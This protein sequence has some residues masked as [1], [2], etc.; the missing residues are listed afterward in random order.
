DLLKEMH[1]LPKGPREYTAISC[2]HLNDGESA[3]MWKLYA[4]DNQGIA[5]QSTVAKLENSL[6]LPPVH[7]I[8]M[9]KVKYDPVEV[10]IYD[11]RFSQHFIFFYKRK[12]FEHEQEYRITIAPQD[13][14]SLDR[15][16]GVYVQVNV[17]TLIEKVYIAPAAPSWFADLV[18]S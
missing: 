14:D 18:K 5:I 13:F 9:G 6:I 15:L 2:W 7:Q 16:G 11:P 8:F 3:A 12:S 1:N 17:A 4:T 10:S